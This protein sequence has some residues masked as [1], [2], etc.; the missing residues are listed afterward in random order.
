MLAATE[1]ARKMPQTFLEIMN[2][3]FV[4]HDER[5]RYRLFL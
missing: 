3:L 4:N 1:E 5:Y 2:D